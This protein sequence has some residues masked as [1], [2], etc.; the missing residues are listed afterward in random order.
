MS[1]PPAVTKE[2][3]SGA[4][5]KDIPSGD[6]RGG[7]ASVGQQIRDVP[8]GGQIKIRVEPKPKE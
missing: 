6:N 8:D 7:G 1:T 3:G 4:D 5:V 2:G